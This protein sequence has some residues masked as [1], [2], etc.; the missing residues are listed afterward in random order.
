MLRA[1]RSGSYAYVA[2]GGG[3]RVIDVANPIAPTEMGF[4]DTPGYGTGSASGVA[5]AGDYA[6]VADGDGGLR[7]IDITNPLDPIEVGFYDIQELVY[8]VVVTEN[9]AYVAA[10]YGGLL[11]VNIADPTAPTE[12]GRYDTPGT[13]EGVTVV[14]TY[15]YIADGESGLR[16]ID[17]AIPATPIEVGFF[18]T[19]SYAKGVTVIGHYAHVADAGSGLHVI[20][21][22]NP[23]IPSEVSFYETLESTHDVA[24]TGNYAYVADSAG[25]LVIL[26]IKETYSISGQV[27]SDGTGLA[28]V[29]LSASAVHSTTTDVNGSYTLTGLSPGNY[30]LTPSKNGYT[31][32]PTFRN[33]SVP[34]DA[35]AQD[36]TA[37]LVGDAYEPDDICAQASVL[38]T[39]GIVQSH[40]FHQYTDADWASFAVVSG[41]TYIVQATSKS[42]TADLELELHDRCDHAVI[43]D[44]NAFGTSAS[45]VF[46]AADNGVYYVRALNQ[47]PEVYGLDVTYELSVRA[48]T[49]VVSW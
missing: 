4:C 19:P 26:Q 20:D 18:D 43:T 29:S 15:A 37:T 27:L 30:A 11:V 45:V 22:T 39:N 46:Q 6:Y 9:Y 14:G 33:V 40:S 41:T 23:V 32:I 16:V 10:S 2:D 24:V 48:Q 36:F 7:V 21:I 34:P 17:V 38:T 12:V 28:G 13:A 25:G 47:L 3:L 1:W 8:D 5:V 31:F 42:A 44:T 35:S 49:P